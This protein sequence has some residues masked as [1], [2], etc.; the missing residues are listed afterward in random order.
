ME[1]WFWRRDVRHAVAT[2]NT[3]KKFEPSGLQPHILIQGLNYGA[4]NIVCLWWRQMMFIHEK[5]VLALRLVVAALLSLQ[6]FSL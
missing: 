1:V 2:L 4:A 5:L 3:T 6:Q